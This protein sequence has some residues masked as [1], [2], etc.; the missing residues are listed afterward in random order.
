M[1]QRGAQQQQ[2]RA[3]VWPLPTHPRSSQSVCRVSADDVVPTITASRV[4]Q[5][6]GPAAARAPA[7]QQAPQQL[8]QGT[9]AAHQA[10]GSGDAQQQPQQPPQQ[11]VKTRFIAE[12]LL[13][14][15]HGRFRLRGYKHSVSAGSRTAECACSTQVGSSAGNG[16]PLLLRLRL[17]DCRIL[18]HRCWRAGHCCSWTVAPPLPSPP[19]SS[20]ARWR[21]KQTCVLAVPQRWNRQAEPAV[22]SFFVCSTLQA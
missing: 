16:L 5:P 15:R 11:L 6:A 20:A 14:T 22:L 21:A 10:G 9:A 17:T 18:L 1:G 4:E 2:W 3:V 19:P 7:Q 8:Q 13:P 12:T